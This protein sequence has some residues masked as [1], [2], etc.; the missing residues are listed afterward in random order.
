MS[1]TS[2]PATL[3]QVSGAVNPAHRAYLRLWGLLLRERRLLAVAAVGMLGAALATALFAALTGPGLRLLFT[4]GAPPTWLT[5]AL[6]ERVRAL[7]PARLRLALPVALFLVS[8]AR[9]GF[10]YLHASRMARLCLRTVADLQEA[11]HRCLLRLPFS[12]FEGRHTGEVYARLAGDLGHV[13]RALLQGFAYSLRDVAQLAALGAIALALDARLLLF[14]VLTLPVGVL[15]IAWFGRRLRAVSAELQDRQAQLVAKT[16]DA[17]SGAILLRV[18][19]ASAAPAR[20]LGAAEDAV[21]RGGRRSAALRA[22]VT[23]TI[24]L[25]AYL[26]V[27]LVTVALQRRWVDVPPEKVVSFF[28]AVLLAYQPLK[29]LSTNGQWVVPG[30]TAAQRLFDLLDQ[31]PALRDE[32]GAVALAALPAPGGAALAFA[33]VEVRYGH[34]RALAE[35]DLAVRPGER[36]AI[37]GPSGAGKS[38]LLHL[39]PRLLDPSAGEVRVNGQAL[40]AVTLASLRRQVALVSQDVFLFDATVAENL[41]PSGRRPSASEVADA[42]ELACATEVVQGL[43]EG[44]A[45]RLGERGQVLSGGQRQRL[46][47]ARA[48]LK[49]GAVLLFDEAT[50]ALDPPLERE[51]LERL[52][53]RPRGSTFVAVTHRLVSA[54]LFERVVVLEGGRIVEDGPPAQ[55]LTRGGWFASH[56]KPP[57]LSRTL[58][59]TIPGHDQ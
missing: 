52:L 25:L 31:A 27:A 8:V 47:I 22:A 3:A 34:H 29:S 23:P 20:R 30:L 56:A 17:V 39:I 54:Q 16:Q 38:T 4:G 13:E 48:L 14:G 44:L 12:F 43:P 49:A 5:G 2:P 57:A 33:G 9:A 40:R 28:G 26:G 35:L 51:I 10:G 7:S 19:R 58:P 37:V 11:L 55:L 42:L 41:A 15:A 53:A 24:E 21:V 46:S 6:G 45:T 59:F 50:S 36:V 18:Y 1:A 32:P